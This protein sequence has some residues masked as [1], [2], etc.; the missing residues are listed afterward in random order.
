MKIVVFVEGTAG[1]RGALRR[2]FQEFFTRAGIPDG[3]IEIRPTGDGPRT[4]KAFERYCNGSNSAQSAFLLIDSERE[5]AQNTA[6][7]RFAQENSNL[8]KPTSASE[9]SLGLMV[10]C[11]E[12]WFLAD[13][14]SA[15]AYFRLP[16]D[17]R[18]LPRH[19]NPESVPKLEVLSAF[20]S[21][22][23]RVRNRRYQKGD[24]ALALLA[25][26]QPTKIA[27]K[28]PHARIFFSEVMRAAGLP[29]EEPAQ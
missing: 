27:A 8:Q 24:D 23:R 15:I 6:N 3:T 13:R 4:H 16:G 2:T 26:A 12:T 14:D 21:A 18:P 9:E 10:Q 28:C 11:M 22:S 20:D 7:W 19:A 5:K 25:M 1:D 17:G 29:Y